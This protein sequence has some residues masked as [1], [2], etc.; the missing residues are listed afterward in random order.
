M[1]GIY[2]ELNSQ[3]VKIDFII[4]RQDEISKMLAENNVLLRRNLGLFDVT[5]TLFPIESECNL[6]K[7]EDDLTSEQ[8]MQIVSKF[9]K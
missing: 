8:R 9:M 4:S 3:K 6:K 7:L 5:K 2:Y 1:E